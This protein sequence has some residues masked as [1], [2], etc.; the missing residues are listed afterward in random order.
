[1]PSCQ[2]SAESGHHFLVGGVGGLPIRDGLRQLHNLF[3]VLVS[4]EVIVIRKPYR[5]NAMRRVKLWSVVSGSWSTLANF[6]HHGFE[7]G[8]GA[9]IRDLNLKFFDLENIGHQ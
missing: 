1:M 2:A 3:V 9:S 8:K 4:R 5:R 6:V 7:M